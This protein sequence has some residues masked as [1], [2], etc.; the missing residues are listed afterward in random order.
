M[1]LKNVEGCVERPW[2]KPLSACLPEPSRALQSSVLCDGWVQWISQV[3]DGEKYIVCG[4]RDDLVF[5]STVIGGQIQKTV[6]I[7]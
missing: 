2:V 1:Y 7:R 6:V 4:T 5:V 3:D